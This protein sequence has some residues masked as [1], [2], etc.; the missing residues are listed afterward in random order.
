MSSNK[1]FNNI[2][3]EALALSFV[4]AK[5]G[6]L[7]VSKALLVSPII[8]HQ[9]LLN[10]LAR[11]NTAVLSFEKYLIENIGYFS[12]FNDRFYGALTSSV[13]AIQLLSELGVIELRDDLVRLLREI[14]V[15]K[16]MGVRADKVSKAASNI[17]KLI[18]E[19]EEITYLNLRIEL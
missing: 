15:S 6:D 14:D 2:G 9:A 19:K 18:S 1:L 4:L 8:S 7:S 13:N 16:K 10:H 17:A 3:L 11:K 5:S 12:N